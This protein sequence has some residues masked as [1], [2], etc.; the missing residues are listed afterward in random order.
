MTAA[1]A[2]LLGHCATAAAPFWEISKPVTSA[3]LRGVHAVDSKVVWASG[4]GGTFLKTVN[5]GAN[6]RA[7]QVHGAEALDFRD[8]EAFDER[9]ALLL[10]SGP[11][12]QSRIYRTTDG[13]QT[14]DLRF[15]NPDPDGFLDA[16]A[17]W[18]R[19]RGIA[20]GDPVEG[21]FRVFLTGDGGT[22]W[23]LV[24]PDGMPPALPEEGA[25]AASGTCL[26]TLRGSKTAWFG[27][28]GAAVSRVFRSED[29]GNHWAIA[30]TPVRA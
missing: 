26:V 20:F 30:E 6:W 12:D 19:D 22:T 13:G 27:T 15:T 18:D 24:P 28:G 21:R 5:A 17:F 14:W 7:G 9:T 11:G 29:G 1:L 3:K 25:F 2:L 16:L 23:R 4:T 8:V 10:A